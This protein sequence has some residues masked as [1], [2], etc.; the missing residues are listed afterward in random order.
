MGDVAAGDVPVPADAIQASL[1]ASGA[2]AAAVD[3]WL[4]YMRLGPRAAKALLAAI[5]AAEPFIAAQAAAAERERLRKEITSTW[6]HY[7]HI[8]KDALLNLLEGDHDD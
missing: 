3:A 7:E 4:K 8:S 6:L 5:R 2:A 1:A